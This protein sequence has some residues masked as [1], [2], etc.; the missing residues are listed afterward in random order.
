MYRISKEWSLSAIAY[1]RELMST[2]KTIYF[3]PLVNDKHGRCYG[4]FYLNIQDNLIRMSEA[5][6]LNRYAIYLGAGDF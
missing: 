5:L 4:E 1:T 6:V 2:A 3:D